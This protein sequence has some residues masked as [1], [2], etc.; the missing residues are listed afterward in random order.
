MNYALTQNYLFFD[1][2]QGLT[3]P[4]DYITEVE[5]LVLPLSVP[6]GRRT[7]DHNLC[8]SCNTQCILMVK[9]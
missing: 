4:H 9:L 5:P 7:R 2:R 1:K 8:R 6:E 3:L